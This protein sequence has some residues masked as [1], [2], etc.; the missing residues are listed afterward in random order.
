M[1]RLIFQHLSVFLHSFKPVFGRSKLF[2]TQKYRVWDLKWKMPFGS[3]EENLTKEE[4]SS[5]FV[6]WKWQYSHKIFTN[7]LPVWYA[8]CDW[9]SFSFYLTCM[10]TAF[11]ISL[12]HYLSENLEIYHLLG[13]IL[14]R[15][16]YWTG[17]WDIVRQK[18]IHK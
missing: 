5:S 3:Y 18:R 2:L 1:Y 4:D 7:I 12:P 16:S 10:R 13:S 8:S 9:I 14:H 11:Q 15:S 17:H 6:N